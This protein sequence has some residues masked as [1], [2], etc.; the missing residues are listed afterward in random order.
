MSRAAEWSCLLKQFLLLPEHCDLTSFSKNPTAEFGICSETDVTISV[1]VQE[2]SLA[3]YCGCV[4]MSPSVSWYRRAAWL[5]LLWMCPDVTIRAWFRRTAWLSTV[6]VS[7]RQRTRQ[8]F[9]LC[10][11][12][13]APSLRLLLVAICSRVIRNELLW[14]IVFMQQQF[15]GLLLMLRWNWVSLLCE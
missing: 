1:L 6:D 9:T 11:L 3:V 7:W 5:S 12:L 4:L 10:S 14:S 8:M 15:C 2:G 13:H